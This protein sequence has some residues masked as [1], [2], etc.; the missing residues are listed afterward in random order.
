MQR[1]SEIDPPSPALRALKCLGF[2]LVT[3]IALAAVQ[4]EFPARL[5]D[6]ILL[7][8]LSLLSCC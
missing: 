1:P 2:A 3:L 6:L 4:P 5:Y 8:E 7:A